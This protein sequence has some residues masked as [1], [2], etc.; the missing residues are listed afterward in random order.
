MRRTFSIWFFLVICTIKSVLPLNSTFSWEELL[1]QAAEEVRRG[2][3]EQALEKL[4]IA[5]ETGEARDFRYY[6]V[7]G[8]AQLGQ[9]SE[10]DALRNFRLSLQ[11]QPDQQPLL[12]EMT[13][14]YDRLRLP[15]KALET[16]RVILSKQPADAELRY[17]AMI[18]ASR[19]GDLQYYKIAL[20]E[21]ETSNPY[22][23]EERALLD[24][25]RTLQSGKKDDEVI[26]R[27]R[28]FLPFFPQNKDLH[29]IC[30]LSYKN[31]DPKLFEDG[32]IRR[33]V[34]FR[35]DPVFQHVLAMEYLDQKRYMDSCALARRALLLA[36]QQ[37]AFPEKDYLVPIRRIYLQNGSVNDTLA[38]DLLE[39]VLL[40]KKRL[41]S[42][43]WETL[44]KQTRFN[45]EILSFA[46][47]KMLKSDRTDDSNRMISRL[48]E[49]YLSLRGPERE[50]DLSR[51]AGPYYLDKSFETFLENA[52]V[53]E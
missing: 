3:Y 45:W 27:C 22:A 1:Q 36:L 46:I 21:L 23:S 7:L 35:E 15:D 10:L 29:R 41:S 11:L 33:A 18:W 24:E 9:G 49:R 53:E 14:L 32:L 43:E 52:S 51:F 39:E 4:R 26:S 40:K 20:Q 47:S 25:I 8:K 5:D 2:R 16:A 30:L 37:T 31:K 19:T 50:K 48:R 38:M 34:V 44:L 6:W 42:D 17:R 13:E 28:K 12:R